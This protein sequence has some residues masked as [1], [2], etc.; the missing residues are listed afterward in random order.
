MER[1]DEWYTHGSK[2]KI[3]RNGESGIETNA[4]E[5]LRTVS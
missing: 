1:M 5:M 4:L 2:E 3:R